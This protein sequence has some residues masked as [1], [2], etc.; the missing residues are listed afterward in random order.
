MA[1]TYHRCRCGVDY[2]CPWCGSDKSFICPTLNG[3]ENANQCDECEARVTQEM[4]A[5]ERGDSE[6]VSGLGDKEN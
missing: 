1:N 5:W 4:E 6:Y 2:E 3:D